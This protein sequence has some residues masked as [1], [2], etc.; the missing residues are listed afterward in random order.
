[1]LTSWLT[2]AKQVKNEAGRVT[3]PARAE[4]VT[5]TVFVF[6]MAAV[7]AVFFLAVDSILASCI[8]WLIN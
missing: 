1:M 7:M 4:V 5:T 3:W 6:I 8:Q 2:F